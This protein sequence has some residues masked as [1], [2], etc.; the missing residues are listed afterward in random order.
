MLFPIVKA[1]TF[2][3]D[4]K[5]SKL[6]EEAD[7]V[8]DIGGGKKPFVK[9]H[10]LTVGD[11]RYAGIDIDGA[12]LAAA[13]PETYTETHV[14]D[15]TIPQ[16]AL[17]GQFDLAICRN[18]LEHVKNN[19]VAVSTII[20][21]LQ[22]RGRAFIKLPCKKAAFARL[23]TILPN[24]L[25]RRIM[26]AVFP[27]KLGDGFPAYYDRCTPSELHSLLKEH[28]VVILSETRTY[29]SSYFSFFLPLHI[30]WRIITL[31]QIRC[32]PDYCEA[33][34]IVFEKKGTVD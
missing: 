2:P 19:K 27:K 34:A 6:F 33:F 13:P 7:Q 14:V 11:K 20:S 8:I 18:T 22:P 31:F 17:A 28:D 10:N 12:E 9:A 15:L 5:P 30:I 29:W 25:K 4:Y 26:H 23:N 16:S 32:D 3:S 21:L 1:T 24:E